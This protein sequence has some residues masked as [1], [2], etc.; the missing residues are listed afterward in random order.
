[1][2]GVGVDWKGVSGEWLGLIL[3]VGFG[4]TERRGVVGEGEGERSAGS[5]AVKLEQ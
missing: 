3:G 4:G 2:V 1:M 5:E